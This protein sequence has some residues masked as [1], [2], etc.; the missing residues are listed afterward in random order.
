MD[1]MNK[2]AED[3]SAHQKGGMYCPH[4]GKQVKLNPVDHESENSG[5]GPDVTMDQAQTMPLDELRKKL[6]KKAE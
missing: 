4:C 3:M 1:E 5:D 6:P 2:E